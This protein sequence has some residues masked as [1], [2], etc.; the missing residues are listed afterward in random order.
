MN[1]I[2]I[3]CNDCEDHVFEYISKHRDEVT[4][5]MVVDALH[6]CVE[7]AKRKYGFLGSRLIAV[8]CAVGPRVG[9]TEF[10][11]PQGEDMSAHAS[12]S[13]DHLRNHQHPKLQSIVVPCLSLNVLVAAF[14]R[15]VNRLYIDLEGADVDVLLG[16]D[17]AQFHPEFVEYE[18]LHSDGT[19]QQGDKNQQLLK[20]LQ[21]NRYS[22]RQSVNSAYNIEA[23]L[24]PWEPGVPKSDSEESKVESVLDVIIPGEIKNDSFYDSLR[25]LA[26][27]P[28]VRTILEI[29]SSAGGGSTEAFVSGL[30]ERAEPAN[31]YCMEISATRFARLRETYEA[32]DFVQCFNA[33]S[34]PLSDFPSHQ[35]VGA[36]WDTV[37]SG[38]RAYPKATVLGWLDADRDYVR[39]HGSDSNG[40][41]LIKSE[42]GIEQ[43]DVVLIDG[44][45]FTGEAELRHVYGAKYIALD[46]IS[47]YKNWN[48]YFKLKEDPHYELIAEERSVR[49]GY[50]VFKRVEV[51]RELPIHF[52][53]IVLNGMPFIRYHIDMMRALPFDWH[54][55]IVEGV[56]DL[57]HDTAWSVGNGGAVTED[58]HILGRSRDGTTQYLDELAAKYPDKVSIY[59]KAVGSFWEGKV[60]MVNAPLGNIKRECL[61]WEIDADELW[62]AEKIT[63]ARNLFLRDHCLT[64]AFYWCHF[65]V[66]P[67]TAVSTRNCYS[68]NPGMEWL[69]T[70]RYVPSCR[71]AAHEPPR[72]AALQPDG[73][74]ADQ[75][76]IRP[77][78]H[79]ETEAAGLVFHHYA[80]ATPAQ[81]HF[82]EVYYGY[83]HAV[84][85]WKRLQSNDRFPC[86]L[87]DYFP[88]VHDET[89]VDTID[90]LGISTVPGTDWLFEAG[91]NGEGST[92]DIIV[93]AVFFQY[94]NTGIARVWKSLLA[95]WA[96]TDFGKRILILDRAGKAPRIAGLRY[97]EFPAHDYGNI[98]LD[99]Q[100]IQKVCD[101]KNARLF[102]SSYYT[103]PLTTPSILLVYDMIP[104]ILKTDLN[105]PMWVEKDHAI[106][107]ASSYVCISANTA[108]DLIKFHPEIMPGSVAVSHTGVGFHPPC[109]ERLDAFRNKYGIE[110]PYF[111]ICGGRSS[112]KNVIQ[113][114]EAFAR[115]NAERVN[116]AILCTGPG[117]SLQP[118]FAALAGNASI[119]LLDLPDE[120]LECAYAGAIALVYPS[121]YEGFGMPIIEAMAC[122]CPVIACPNGPIPEV[123][124]DA[125]MFVSAGDVDE[126]YQALQQIQQRDRRDAL[127]AKGRERAAL[128]SWRKMA[129]DIAAIM[130]KNL[131]TP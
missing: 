91:A 39:S 25:A 17:L 56:A 46:D 102:I 118:E 96:A 44:S 112:Y 90:R 104:E 124:G 111:L 47:T 57:K 108:K 54:W 49:N 120:E 88:W 30:Q 62:T 125:A 35:T 20:L 50:C 69:R 74:W 32:F 106:K 72:L 89:E 28:D 70:W 97:L 99:Q 16:F 93:D 64:S 51:Q 84:E 24:T 128:F 11:F 110:R 73:G 75:S 2:Q 61:L 7:T 53:T 65:F 43:F 8:N 12:M 92:E 80:Y 13:A 123:A 26:M 41:Q 55:H 83:R 36:F 23:Q 126:M 10:Y 15:P 119:H 116:F 115:F 60:E 82:K 5:F 122:A 22:Y 34:V 76:A 68:Q 48:N 18:Y 117:E 33:S 114:F 129:D 14:A 78:R 9:L 77:L 71:W 101:Y 127:I 87:K 66:G 130:M 67:T 107:R 63:S 21:A 109:S 94:Y 81:L 1:I 29:G 27:L 85:G 131:A 52:V 42:R 31:L 38:L 121:L 58:L 103:S 4:A 98:L 3:G 95:E 40:I 100:L 59:R 19:F 6:G 79:A 45:E 105:H 86:R 37:Q 113:F